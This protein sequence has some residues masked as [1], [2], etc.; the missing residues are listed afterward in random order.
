MKSWITKTGQKIYQVLGGRC[1]C[2]LIS[3]RN[4]HLLIDTGRENRWKELSKGLDKLGVNDKSL[5]ALILTHS[6]FDHAE[7]AANIK[8]KY[9]TAI[10]IHKSE[11]DYLQRG[12]NPVI[13]G[14][15]FVTRLI[16]D[17]LAKKLVLRYIRYKPA[18]YDILVDETYDLN[19]FGFN[20]Y[21]IH[22]P[23]HSL[24]SMS[25]IIEN[26]IAI[27]GD[28]M[29]GVFKGSVF[30][31]FA[32]NPKLMVKSWERSLDTGCSTFLPAHGTG[33]SKELL[34]RQYD[35]YKRAYDL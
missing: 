7:N 3:Y 21:I 2:F 31:P 19:D 1:N 27:V 15:T 9:K 23:G 28:A 6:H 13:R 26:E 18:D 20:G 10:I 8:E 30:P 29:F 11:A 34:Q 17:L 16:T 4:R 33:R 5:I 22:T 32:D 25:V 35:K 24:G 14:T 12:D